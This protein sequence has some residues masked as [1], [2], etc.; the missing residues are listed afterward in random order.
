MHERAHEVGG[1]VEIQRLHE[2]VEVHARLPF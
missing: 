1:T 2:G